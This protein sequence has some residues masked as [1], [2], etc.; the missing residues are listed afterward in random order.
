MY[1][2]FYGLTRNPFEIS[3]DP[4]FFYPTPRHNEALANL[5]YGVQRRKGFVVVT[6]EVGTGKTLLVR[7]LLD[8]LNRNQVSF[9]YVF[10]PRLS[11]L[12]FLRYV[13]TDLRLPMTG[14]TKSEMLAHLNS[15]LIA[16]FR[17]GTT[18]ALVVDEAQLLSW[19]LLEEIRLLTNLETSQQKLLQIVLVGQ[20]ELDQKLDSPHLRQLKQRVGLRCRLEP[21]S[22]EELRGYIH[23]R[24]ELAGANSHGATI[25]ADGAIEAVH[26]FSR[27]IPRLIN[28]L[29][30]NALVSGY[31]RQVKQMTPEIIAEVAADFRLDVSSAVEGPEAADAETRKK[32]LK[33]LFRM[34]E[35]L[36]ASPEKQLEETKFESGVKAE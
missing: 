6:G 5:N 3:P 22:L 4:Y 32:A 10:N 1:R 16:R 13:L 27:G 26:R 21:L 30:E 36:E 31:A 25:F 29:C 18:A 15:Y 11:V 28:T 23:R 8:A 19:E 20:P 35:E 14:G 34:I 17:R 9:A 7:C 24:L 33:T 2:K 12:D